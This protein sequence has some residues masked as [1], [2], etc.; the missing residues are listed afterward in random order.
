[1]LSNVFAYGSLMYA[2]VWRTVTNVQR[3][4]VPARLPGYAR[5]RLRDADYPCAVSSSLQNAIKGCL[6]FDID[7]T[8]LVKLDAFEGLRY[9]RAAVTCLCRGGKLAQAYVYVL[10]DSLAYLVDARPWDSCRFAQSGLRRFL[11]AYSGFGR[12]STDIGDLS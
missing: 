1:M 10:Q 8:T 3:R 11:S 4:G 9:R 12:A 7:E 6:Y 2:P 5:F